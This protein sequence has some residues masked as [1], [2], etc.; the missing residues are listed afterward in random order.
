MIGTEALV[1]D[2]LDKARRSEYA[3]EQL[4][5]AIDKRI[6]AGAPLLVTTNLMPSQLA[7]RFPGYGPMI[8]S[9]LRGYCETFLVEGP[10][11][12]LERFAS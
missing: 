10:D 1:L 7:D 12:R 5:C 3:S 9:R 6:T 11:R 4:L 8:V 2:D